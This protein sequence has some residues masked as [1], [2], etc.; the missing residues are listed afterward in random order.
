MGQSQD[1]RDATPFARPIT[2][3]S[4][5]IKTI[6]IFKTGF[7]QTLPILNLNKP[8]ESLELHF[9][10]LSPNFKNYM[11]KIVH[12]TNDWSLSDLNFYDYAD[13]LPED[14]ITK[15]NSSSTIGLRYTHYAVKFPNQNFSFKI[16]GNY[17]II[18]YDEYSL[19]TLLEVG[20]LVFEKKVQVEAFPQRASNVELRY[21]GQEIDFN[22]KT[23][24]YRLTNPFQDLKVYILQNFRYDNA[25]EIQP[26]FVKADE[27]EYNYDVENV[28]LGGNEFRP[29]DLRNLSINQTISKMDRSGWISTFSTPNLQKRNFLNYKTNFDLNGRFSDASQDNFFNPKTSNQYVWVNFILDKPYLYGDRKV[30]VFGEL[31]NWNYL[32]DF[33][34]ELNPESNHMEKKILLKQ[35]YYNYQFMV[36]Q[37]N[38]FANPLGNAPWDIEGTHYETENEY[39]ILIYHKAPGTYYDALVGFEYLKFPLRD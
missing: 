14:Y 6:Q 26:L 28:F 23:S 31:S 21:A 30:Y 22:I 25:I 8:N 7:E 20:F 39:Q 4:D 16:S 5:S 17:K 38:K 27:L 24:S 1:F 18:V 33:A 3:N 32:D 11:Y 9:D 34:L 29:L 10:F 35:G 2:A 12:C 15:I 19:D 37:P 36:M 13:G